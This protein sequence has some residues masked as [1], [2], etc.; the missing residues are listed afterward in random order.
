MM[1]MTSEYSDSVLTIHICRYWEHFN[2]NCSR[3]LVDC[4]NWQG[5]DLIAIG[6]LQFSIRIWRQSGKRFSGR[7][8]ERFLFVVTSPRKCC[9][10]TITPNEYKAPKQIPNNCCLLPMELWP[11]HRPTKYHCKYLSE[12]TFEVSQK[13]VIQLKNFSM[14]QLQMTDKASLR[15]LVWMQLNCQTCWFQLQMRIWQNYET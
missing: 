10:S 7:F 6:A 5:R 12:K 9:L 14:Y 2:L 13:Q 4:A 15:H 1:M 3:L 11:R 8:Y